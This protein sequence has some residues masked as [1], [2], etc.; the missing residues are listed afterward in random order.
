MAL[1][2]PWMGRGGSEQRVMRMIE[3]LAGQYDLTLITCGPVDLDGLNAAYE[4]AVRVEDLR[5]LRAPLPWWI[6]PLLRFDAVRGSWYARFCKRVADRFDVLISTY[7]AIDFGRPAIQCI[8]DFCFDDALRRELH[9]SPVGWRR[10]LYQDNFLRRA[11]R[12]FCR[13]LAG[14]RSGRDPAGDL[15]LATS[16]WSGEMMRQRHGATCRTVYPAVA[17]AYPD[18]DDERI[19]S[20]F[21]CLGRIVIEKRIE[22]IIEILQ[23]VRDAGHDVHLHVV[24]PVGNTAYARRI[25]SLCESRADWVTLAGGVFGEAKRR[26]L[27][28]HRYGIHACQG[29]SFGAAVAEMVKAGCIPL[30]SEVGGPAEIVQHP[31][32]V[33]SG[34]DDAVAKV[35]AVLKDAALRDELRKHLKR[36]GECFSVE[37]FRQEM[38]AVVREFFVAQAAQTARREGSA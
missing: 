37:R 19:E 35:T 16:D 3:A 22:R 11:Y 28:S 5:V 21:I 12:R 14:P 31:A 15:Y 13:F 9:G 20:G 18:G 33:F 2:H 17:D 6:R 34:V 25:E 8:A 27:T 4:T 32:L 38:R 7:N 23:R 10:W 1:A 36:R 30:V 29:E 26:L 24:G